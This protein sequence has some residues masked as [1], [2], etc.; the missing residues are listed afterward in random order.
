[1]NELE[2]A[3]I[4][5]SYAAQPAHIIEGL[6]DALV[7][8]PIPSAPRT[9][10]AELWHIAFW[11]QMS[12]DWMRGLETPYPATP[13]LPFPSADDIASES[14]EQLCA[15][16]LR[17][18]EEAATIARDTASLDRLIQCPSRPGDPTRTMSIRDQLISLA[19][20]NA[21]HFGRF[22]ADAPASDRG[23]RASGG[24]FTLGRTVQKGRPFQLPA[25]ETS[26]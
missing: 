10:Y 20:H 9:L 17:T 5:D 12:L 11:Q 7:H 19:A 24:F 3:L 22:G 2:Q 15:R 23:R 21:Y 25:E 18:S 8:Q 6:S 14:W 13:E 26:K 16:F 4:G 1:M